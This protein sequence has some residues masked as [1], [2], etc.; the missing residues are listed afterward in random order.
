MLGHGCLEGCDFLPCYAR[1]LEGLEDVTG[2]QGLGRA[3]GRRLLGWEHLMEMA[4]GWGPVGAGPF[5]A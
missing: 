1:G 5:H 4:R 3:V 2:V